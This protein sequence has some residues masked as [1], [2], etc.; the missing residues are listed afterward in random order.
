[1]GELFVL[2]LIYKV[3]GFVVATYFCLGACFIPILIGVG[4]RK[5]YFATSHPILWWV[6]HGTI[7]AYVVVHA[8]IS[9]A[10]ITMNPILGSIITLIAGVFCIIS[11]LGLVISAFIGE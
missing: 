6:I 5:S 9:M 1:M 7:E 10:D 2:N 11:V 3:F 8:I 4:F